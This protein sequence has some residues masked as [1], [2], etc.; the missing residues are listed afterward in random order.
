MSRDDPLDSGTIFRPT[1]TDDYLGNPHKGCCTFQHFNGD[2][3][4]P[5]MKWIEAGPVEFPSP[6]HRTVTYP[7]SDPDMDY[8]TAPGYLPTTVAYCRWFWHAMEPEDDLYD[9]SMIDG[10]LATAHAR[11][12]TLAVRFSPFGYVPGGQPGLP[13]W[14]AKKY[15]TQPYHDVDQCAP[16]YDSPEYLKVWGRLVKEFARRYDADPG[17][18]SVDVA[19]IGP[20][21]EGEGQ[22]SQEQ[23][24]RFAEIYQAAFK[25][26]PRLAL[27]AGDP[28]KGDQ[29]R[30]SV[31]RGSGWRADGFGDLMKPVG[32]SEVPR[33]RE[34]NHMYD[35]YPRRIAEA[36]ARDAWQTA[37]IHFETMW[38]PMFW[39]EHGFDIDFILQQGLKYH[40]TYFMPKHTPLPEPWMEKF[41]AFCRRL[42]YR[43]VFRQA[44]IDRTV[45]PQGSF[46][47]Q[48]W[49]ENVGVAPIYRRYDFALRLR[50]GGSEHIEV[51]H[52][53]D[54]RT[55]LPG[56]VW[57]N[58]QIALPESFRP[59][60]VEIS[61]GLVDPQTRKACV[62]FAIEE[63]FGDRWALLGGIEVDPA[64]GAL[65]R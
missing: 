3:V 39:Y 45:S 14:Y 16:V 24:D 54:I 52:D 37:P 33:H 27:I 2:A 46:G 20:W 22:C 43:Y 44:T 35:C 17:L 59:G 48:A 12:Q 60:W 4:F 9:F 51:L 5:G 23:C 47:F 55:W 61:A 62:N 21:G 34:W 63:R 56:D 57:L 26:T 58:E 25:H 11:G 49:I 18:E 31:S 30:A 29:M 64:G 15:P 7:A 19:F 8:G 40:A 50:Q 53:V 1:P 28:V 10:A 65:R 32:R 13:H 38:V 41:A 42:G 36:G 6:V